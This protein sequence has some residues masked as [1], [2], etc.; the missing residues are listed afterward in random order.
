MKKTALDFTPHPLTSIPGGS[1]LVIH[2]ESGKTQ[3]QPN[4]HYP[5]KYLKK[6]LE[7]SEVGTIHRAVFDGRTI[8]TRGKL[9]GS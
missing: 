6:L 4:C 9:S 8:Y 7:S 2:W 5:E 1:T 3:R